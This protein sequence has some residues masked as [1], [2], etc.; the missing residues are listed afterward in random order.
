MKSKGQ[1]S[2]IVER[3]VNAYAYMWHTSWCL[4]E[5]GQKQEA[6]SH[7]QFMAS[8][9]FTAFTLEAHLNHA[10]L[11]IFLCWDD[12]ERLGPK[13]KLNLIAE[14]LRVKINYGVR[15]WQVMKD[16]FG[17]RNAIAHAKSETIR[18]AAKTVAVED[19]EMR[20]FNLAPTKWELFCTE[21]NAVKARTDVE[22]I[23]VTLHEAAKA[24]GCDLGHPFVMGLQSRDAT[25]L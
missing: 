1:V 5:K 14:H 13:E 22:K 7:H 3:E 25:L 9:V 24:A 21:K 11:K 8:L 2:V 16:L 18:P 17:F 19:Y 10:G 4:L 15:P 6:G 20:T 12:L 23:I